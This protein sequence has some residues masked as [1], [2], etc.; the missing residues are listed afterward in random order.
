MIGYMVQVSELD[1]PSEE[2][3]LMI[4][5]QDV[6]DHYAIPTA[7]AKYAGYMNIPLGKEN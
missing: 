3:W 2:G 6:I 1:L 4:D 5:V 7:F